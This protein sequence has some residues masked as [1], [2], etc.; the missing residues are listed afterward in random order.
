MGR[1]SD[2]SREELHELILEAARELVE[3]EGLQGLT[4]RR[5]AKRIGYAVGTL[6]NLFDSLDDLVVHLNA[7]TLDALYEECSKVSFESEPEA[8]LRSLARVYIRFTGDHRH[9]WNNLFDANV[10]H[11]AR[12]PDWYH[13]KVQR[14]F[15]LEERALAALFPPGQEDERRRS[16]R[17]LWSSLHGI[18][19]LVDAGAMAKSGS[20]QELADTLIANYVAGLRH[21]LSAPQGQMP[22]ERQQ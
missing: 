10:P 5:V 14:L 12:L 7:A 16:A 18:C 17:I 19:S 8:N 3:A 13:A 6:Y 4:T 15:A 20:V 22:L 9:L 1:R 2:H 21:G 11:G